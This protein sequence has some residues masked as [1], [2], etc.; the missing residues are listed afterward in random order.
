MLQLLHSVIQ[1]C[2]RSMNISSDT[3]HSHLE[4]N[5]APDCCLVLAPRH[6]ANT[7]HEAEARPEADLDPIIRGTGGSQHQHQHPG[8]SGGPHPSLAFNV[9]KKVSTFAVQNIG[10]FT[11][12]NLCS[13][14]FLFP[15]H[16]LELQQG[17]P[18]EL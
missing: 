10:F 3:N 2:H 4:G 17:T 7:Q 9:C 13:G 6:T 5:L 1:R 8:G 15:I 18:L 14:H 12:F 16:M 11:S